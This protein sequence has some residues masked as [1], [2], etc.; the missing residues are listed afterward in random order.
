M[1]IIHT[2]NTILIFCL[3]S[4]VTLKSEATLPSGYDNESSYELSFGNEGSFGLISHFSV[5]ETQLIFTTT[6]QVDKIQIYD[7]NNN[8]IFQLPVMSDHFKLGKSLFDKGEY[9]LGFLLSNQN[10]MKF[11]TIKVL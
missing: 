10:S 2:I 6:G 3:F 8:L 11:T 5:E 9:K 4:V 7:T 1:K